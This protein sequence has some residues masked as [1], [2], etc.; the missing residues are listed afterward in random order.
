MIAC[1]GLAIACAILMPTKVV[2][3][4]VSKK[5]IDKCLHSACLASSRGTTELSSTT[6]REELFSPKSTTLLAKY[7]PPAILTRCGRA[8]WGSETQEKLLRTIGK[9]EAITALS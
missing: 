2:R 1:I 4:P 3:A 6:V 9:V 5:K 8:C 7:S